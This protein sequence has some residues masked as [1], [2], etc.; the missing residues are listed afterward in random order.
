M[1][2]QNKANLSFI[3]TNIQCR[4]LRTE[5]KPNQLPPLGMKNT[6]NI[7]KEYNLCKEKNFHYF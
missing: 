7:L 6:K 5:G 2:Y 1:A 4:G 3:I